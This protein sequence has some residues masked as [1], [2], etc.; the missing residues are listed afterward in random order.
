MKR[1][2]TL[3]KTFRRPDADATSGAAG[4]K[5][6]LR[7]RRE[8]RS[9]AM[10]WHY[11]ILDRFRSILRDGFI[12]PATKHVPLGERPIAWFSSNPVW[13]RSAA[14]TF[15]QGGI[16]RTGSFEDH[17]SVGLV[18]IGVHPETAPYRWKEIKELSNMDASVAQELYN[19]AIAEGARPGEWY[20]A[21]DPVPRDAWVSVE[22]CREGEWCSFD[23][24]SLQPGDPVED[25]TAPEVVQRLRDLVQMVKDADVI[26]GRDEAGPFQIGRAH[27]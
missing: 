6:K 8:T 24:S 5:E 20:G 27:V 12:K 10:V 18:R 1:L 22:M 26:F 7:N 2:Q 11:T 3:K 19:V 17:V 9:P 13:E 15:V 23:Y 4:R 25:T 21:F 14:K 16:S